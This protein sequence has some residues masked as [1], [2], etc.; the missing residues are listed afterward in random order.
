MLSYPIPIGIPILTVKSKCFVVV[1]SK[2]YRCTLV[3]LPRILL[4]I[5]KYFIS[6]M[7]RPS[8]SIRQLKVDINFVYKTRRA[9]WEHHH[10][11][12]RRGRA[13]GCH[14]DPGRA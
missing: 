13:L 5:I 9:T 14:S 10:D 4:M 1:T 12:C 11:T 8:A 7:P 6:V 2:T 3:Y